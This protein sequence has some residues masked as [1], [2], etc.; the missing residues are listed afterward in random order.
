MDVI[1]YR[2]GTVASTPVVTAVT[3]CV[4]RERTSA[5]ALAKRLS[6]RKAKA[7]WSKIDRLT[8]EKQGAWGFPQTTNIA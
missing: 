6:G 1:V 5:I 2:Y 3:R 4:V 7:L 8:T